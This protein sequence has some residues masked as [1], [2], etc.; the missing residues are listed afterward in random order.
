MVS[1]NGAKRG[2]LMDILGGRKCVECGMS[3]PLVL[4]ID[5]IRGNGKD[6]PLSKKDVINHY[7]ENPEFARGELQVLCCNCH[8]IKTVR[9]NEIGRRRTLHMYPGS[10]IWY[11]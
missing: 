9:C 11:D 2:M 1:K 6:M 4:Q 7:L 8:R 3:D 5:H 10:S